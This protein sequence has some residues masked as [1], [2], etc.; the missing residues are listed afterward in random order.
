MAQQLLGAVAYDSATPDAPRALDLVRAVDRAALHTAPFDHVRLEQVFP[1]DL[2]GEMLE[3]Y[4]A[5]EYFYEVPHPD[6]LR[7]DGSSTRLQMYLRPENLS[8]LP[9]EQR[10]IWSPIAAVLCSP[11]LE[12]A[13]KRKFRTALEERFRQAAERIPLR[14]MATLVRDLPGYRI[15]IHADV[16]AKAI[17]VQFY[18]PSDGS[19]AHLGTVFHTTRQD[20]GT[21]RPLAMRFLPSSGYAFPV[22]QKES[23]H[24]VPATNEADGERWSIKLTYYVDG[25]SYL[26]RY[27]RSTKRWWRK[28]AGLFLGRRSKSHRAQPGK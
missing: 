24:S 2:Y 7:P 25:G 4:P 1:A 28:Q 6:A 9:D 14:P 20:D 22:R 27:W 10:L 13:F 11:E 8:R 12:A 16:P 23:W 18:L 26:S 15:G 21:D 19:Q 17:T 3:N 5:A